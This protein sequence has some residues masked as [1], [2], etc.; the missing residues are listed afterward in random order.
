MKVWVDFINTPQVNF[1]EGIISQIENDGHQVFITC[2][3]SA[4]TVDLLNVKK[5][6]Y[7]I[8]NGYSGKNKVFKYLFFPLRLFR[9]I[10][11]L[12]KEK[13]NIAICQSSFYLPAAARLCGIYSIYT[14]DNEHAKGNILGFLFANKIFLP[15]VLDKYA[16]TKI[17]FIKKKI[18]FYPG[19]K[20]GIYLCKYIDR[21]P[22]MRTERKTN[23]FYRPEPFTAQYYKGPLYKNDDILIKLAKKY[24]V[25]IMPRGGEQLNH[26]KN[27]KFIDCH[28]VDKPMEFDE[29]FNKCDL[30]I[31]SGGTMTREFAVLGKKVIS[32]YSGQL[33]ESDKFL[34]EKKLML[35][36]SELIEKN[37]IDYI[38]SEL[39]K[40]NSDTI[41]ILTKGEIASKII[42]NALKIK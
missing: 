37:V 16:E 21:L 39:H 9:L 34:L 11:I 14:N 27:S 40:T 4:N 5:L 29:V 36:N 1:F 35:Y 24:N 28:I 19:I 8:V 6:K 23:I 3:D 10:K 26:Y 25:Y 2:R 7:R 31:G 15:E 42:Y 17:S 18:N 30:F 13:L 38:D 32:T 20:E 33:L 12:K 41:E 22:N